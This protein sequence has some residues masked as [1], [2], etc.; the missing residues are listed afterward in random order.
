MIVLAT[1][2]RAASDAHPIL[3]SAQH[4]GLGSKFERRQNRT[5]PKDY[6][7]GAG[8]LGLD[9][10]SPHGCDGIFPIFVNR[11]Q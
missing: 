3:G 1:S 6:G 11:E 10:L 7:V 8:A 4:T 9:I 2:G 5:V